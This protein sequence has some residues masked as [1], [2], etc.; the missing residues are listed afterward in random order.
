LTRLASESGGK[1]TGA[2][3]IVAT[4]FIDNEIRRFNLDGFEK[5]ARALGQAIPV[6]GPR[7]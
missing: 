5:Y 3:P 7:E 6:A 4:C 2:R 1:T